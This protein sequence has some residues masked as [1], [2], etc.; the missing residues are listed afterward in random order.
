MTTGAAGALAHAVRCVGVPGQ[1]IVTFAPFFPEYKPYIE[2]A[3]L[4]LRVTPPRC[5]DFQIDFEA[6]AQLV[7]ENTAAVLSS[8]APTTPAAPPTARRPCS[9]WP[10]F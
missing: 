3:G 4:T 9:S 6:F 1:N 10:P 8:T 7:D 2:G 5:A